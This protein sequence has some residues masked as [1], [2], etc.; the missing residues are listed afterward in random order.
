MSASIRIESD[1]SL[2]C[3]RYRNDEARSERLQPPRAATYEHR[4]GRRFDIKKS[5]AAA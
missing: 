4:K 2:R 3:D 1:F 5:L